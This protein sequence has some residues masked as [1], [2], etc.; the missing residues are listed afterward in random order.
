M[1][2]VGCPA[3]RTMAVV[4]SGGRRNDM[5][6]E[7]RRAAR[8]AERQAETAERVRDDSRAPRIRGLT[9]VR[10]VPTRIEQLI[11]RLHEIQR[12]ED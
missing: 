3:G 6:G 5:V 11:L 9:G 10:T 8:Q 2:S 1:T 12:L 4:A 7:G